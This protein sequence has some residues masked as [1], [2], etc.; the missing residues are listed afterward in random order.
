MPKQALSLG[1]YRGL[2]QIARDGIFTIL[3][4]D[5]RE[6]L[7]KLLDPQD[8]ERIGYGELAEFKVAVAR[9]LTPHASAFLTDVTYGVPQVIGQDALPGQA[10]LLV[11]IEESGY[12]GP[13]HARR[14]RL[15]EGWSVEKIRRVGASA[16]KL[17]LYYHP[18]A[19]AAPQQ[20]ALLRQVAADCRAYDIPLVLEVLTYSPDPAVKADSAGYAATRPWVVAESARRLCPLGVDAFKAEFPADM[21][22]E[23]DEGRL[24]RACEDVTEAAGV[25]WM[26]LSAAVDHDTFCRQVRLACRGGASG[27]LAGRS[28]W[29]EAGALRGEERAQFLAGEATRRLTELSQIA[30]AHARPW[31]EWYA[32]DVDDQWWQRY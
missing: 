10:G 18:Q 16:V 22:F 28:I 25:P 12:L 24:L 4:L 13:A 29:K 32:A 11:T 14:A 6:S 31:G 21:R 30:H 20:E 2:Q 23:K 8:P 7:R 3:A 27:F 1:K 5:H 26:V 9:A 17:L 19:E 15:V